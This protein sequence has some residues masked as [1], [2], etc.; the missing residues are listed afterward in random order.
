MTEKNEKLIP[1]PN[2]DF[3]KD[4]K[5][6]VIS[7]LGGLSATF[8][9]LIF[10]I[11]FNNSNIN[12]D[13]LVNDPINTL[14]NLYLRYSIPMR[15]NGFVWIATFFIYYI[16]NRYDS[17]LRIEEKRTIKEINFKSF[18]FAIYTLFVG[19][20]LIYVEPHVFKYQIL[21]N[22]FGL[23]ITV[24]GFLILVFGRLEI[25]GL[26]GPHVYE[27]KD[28]EFKRLITTGIYKKMR[29]P[30]YYGQILLSFSTFILSQSILFLLFPLSVCAINNYRLKIEE[31]HLLETF[32]KE[33]EEYR[34]KVPKWFLIK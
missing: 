8:L 10:R 19:L 20:G 34:S 5:S 25:D 22:V 16:L 29:H 14:F 15:F 18:T 3:K 33:Y 1:P 32:G 26:W 28:P 13:L 11:I 17:K 4:I 2:N 23:L 21:I 24:L 31:K 9:V 7:I 12:L 6:I 27:Y 30:I